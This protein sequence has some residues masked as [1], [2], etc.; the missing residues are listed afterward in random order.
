MNSMKF[1]SQTK[2]AEICGLE[3]R[4]IRQAIQDGK[5]E[6]HPSSKIDL[7][8]PVNKAYYESSI[9]KV[10]KRKKPIKGKPVESENID[11]EIS[12]DD[13]D[14]RYELYA[15]QE[16]EKI[17]VEIKYKKE[18]TKT[19]I[20][21]RLKDLGLLISREIVQ[22]RLAKLGND[23]SL[24]LLVSMAEKVTN[25]S[26]AIFESGGSKIDALKENRK[27]IEQAVRKVK[28]GTSE[29]ESVE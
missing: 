29:L 12:Q 24:H 1:V 14:E 25:K 27:I 20:Q 5:I 19:V 8:N 16:E 7:E 17:A 26:W 21:K 6:K 9:R 11:P 28:S 3:S 4:T 18:Q 15:S 22:Q 10:A 13:I 23:I 2:F